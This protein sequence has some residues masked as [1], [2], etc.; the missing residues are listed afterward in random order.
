VQQAEGGQQ[1]R[2]MPMNDPIGCL[3]MEFI[4]RQLR[5]LNAQHSLKWLRERTLERPCSPPRK[6][7]HRFHAEHPGPM[8][9]GSEYDGKVT[10]ARYG[11]L[12]S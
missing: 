12:S 6:L 7:R 1:V 5:T 3:D 8:A 4:G 2:E 11:G 9:M 10:V